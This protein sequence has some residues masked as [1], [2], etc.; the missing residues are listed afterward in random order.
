MPTDTDFHLALLTTGATALLAGLAA[1]PL[2]RAVAQRVGAVDLPGDRRVHDRA[3]PRLGGLAVVVAMLAGLGA[4][5][6]LFPDAFRTSE[7][8][9]ATLAVGT[10][11]CLIGAIDD[12]RGLSPRGKLLA[13]FAIAAIA[14]ALGLRITAVEVPWVGPVALGLLSLPFTIFWIAGASHAMNLIDGVDGLAGTVSLVA[15]VAVATSA[16]IA[17]ATGHALLALALAG[18]LIAFLRRNWHPASVFLGD[19]GSLALGGLLAALAVIGSPTGDAAAVWGLGPAMLLAYPMGDTS[20][21]LARR[22]LRGVPLSS[23]DRDH[24]HHRL[25]AAGVR[26]PMPALLIGTWS[27]GAVTIAIAAR[28]AGTAGTQN[29]LLVGGLLLGALSLR[30]LGRLRFVEFEAFAAC[31]ESALR[32][33]IPTTRERIHLREG[34]ARIAAAPHVGAVAQILAGTAARIGLVHA[35]LTRSSA[36]RALPPDAPVTVWHLDW[37][38]DGVDGDDP[39]VLRIYGEQGGVRPQSAGRFADTF[40]PA[41]EEWLTLPRRQELRRLRPARRSV[42]RATGGPPHQRTDEH[43]ASGDAAAVRTGTGAAS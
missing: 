5:W 8:L 16:T 40:T 9:F 36:R 32:F 31:V 29:L 1:L 23:A 38:L 28:H 13:T 12:V 43:A 33:A 37:P 20:I 3:T 19:S 22:W 35:E 42:D 25:L 27:A 21:A 30:T 18:A 2:V 11:F 4:A 15:A 10:G 41:V 34:A 6:I 39:I 7:A 26:Q 17:G 14:Y 24:V